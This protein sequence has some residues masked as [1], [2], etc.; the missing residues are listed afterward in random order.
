MKENICLSD[1]WK[2]IS[3]QNVLKLLDLNNK[4]LSN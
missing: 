4:R 1:I 3:I 2:G